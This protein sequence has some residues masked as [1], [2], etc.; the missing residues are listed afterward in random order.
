MADFVDR[1]DALAH[2]WLAGP[3]TALLNPFESLHIKQSCYLET[4]EPKTRTRE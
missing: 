2:L 4:G 3:D 1:Y